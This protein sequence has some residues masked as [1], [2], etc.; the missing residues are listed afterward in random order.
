M[1]QA[2]PW[3]PGVQLSL[4]CARCCHSRLVRSGP[5]RWPR[6]LVVEWLQGRREAEQPAGSGAAMEGFS[7]PGRGSGSSLRRGDA[8]KWRP[9]RIPGWEKLGC[10]AGCEVA[11]RSLGGGMVVSG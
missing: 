2:V 8:A 9:L 5:L 3:R 6:G 7:R 1:A 10:E 4:F 11:E